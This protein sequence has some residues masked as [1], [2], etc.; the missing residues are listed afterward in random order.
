MQENEGEGKEKKR[1]ERTIMGLPERL[2]QATGL[3]ILLFSYNLPS[4]IVRP[5]FKINKLIAY[6]VSIGLH[7][8]SY[9]PTSSQL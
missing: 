2:N 1:N 3:E 9:R 7:A 5:L 8:V 4:F 6:R